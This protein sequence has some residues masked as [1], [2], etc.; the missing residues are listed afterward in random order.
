MFG[1]RRRDRPTIGETA[2][3]EHLSFPWY[4]VVRE[5]LCIL[6]EADFPT[7]MGYKWGAYLT[8]T[9]ADVNKDTNH[10]Y[11]GG[12]SVKMTTGNLSGDLS[13]LKLAM[14]KAFGGKV[15]FEMRWLPAP[16]YGANAF[17]FGFENRTDD[18]IQGRCR[19]FVNTDEW[20]YESGVDVYSSFSPSVVIEQPV[21][22]TAPKGSGDVWG[23]ARLVLD[24]DALAYVKFQCAGKN[25]LIERNMQG[26]PLVNRGVTATGKNQ[27]LFFTIGYT[28][29]A[30]NQDF[31]TTDWVI[32]RLKA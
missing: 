18:L 26:I 11:G 16:A 28:G 5:G 10:F 31:W 2:L 22:D 4:A 27:Y 15:A 30:A 25:G 20:Q 19:Y 13:E 17:H 29:A 8:G 14:Q 7:T 32:S 9:G 12:G 3:G 21:F 6:S 23:W 1:G 24:L